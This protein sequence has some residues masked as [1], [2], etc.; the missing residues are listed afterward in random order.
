M[1]TDSGSELDDQVDV[2]R[3]VTQ[4][5]AELLV[6]LTRATRRDLGIGHKNLGL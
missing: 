4:D 6:E 3:R 5:R 2:G 1:R